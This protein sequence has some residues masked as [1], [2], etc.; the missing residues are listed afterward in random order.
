MVSRVELEC[1]HLGDYWMDQSNTGK[2]DGHDIY[3]L[4]FNHRMDKQLNIFARVIN[5][6]DE[7][8]ATAASISRGNNEFA[9]GM[10]RTLYAGVDYKF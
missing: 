10:P 9:L 4:R 1:V 2:Y 3:H 7:L 5:V 6:T 8:Y